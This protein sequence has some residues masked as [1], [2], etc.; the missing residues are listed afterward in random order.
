MY[1]EEQT[2]NVSEF[3]HSR[4]DFSREMSQ[5]FKKDKA[6]KFSDEIEGSLGHDFVLLSTR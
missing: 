2:G 6:K 3:I 1:N 4:P 5:L